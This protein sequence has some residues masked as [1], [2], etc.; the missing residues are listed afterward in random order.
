[1]RKKGD[2]MAK[3]Q[4]STTYDE[5]TLKNFQATCDEYGLKA[6]TVLEALM[7]YFT[8]GDCKIVIDKSGISIETK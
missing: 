5:E 6:N 1:M 8:N 4:W 7:K 2:N 3:K